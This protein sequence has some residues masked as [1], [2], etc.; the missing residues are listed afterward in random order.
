M[1]NFATRLKL[2]PFISGPDQ[3]RPPN[4]FST[5]QVKGL[6]SRYKTYTNVYST[7]PTPTIPGGAK[8]VL[9]FA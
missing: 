1:Q 7:K 9:K 6:T 5:F 2:P 8:N 4:T 3:A